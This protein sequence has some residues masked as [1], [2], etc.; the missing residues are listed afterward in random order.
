MSTTSKA[1][2]TSSNKKITIKVSAKDFLTSLMCFVFSRATL[3]SYMNPFGMAMYAANFTGTGWYWAL[4][5]AIT[6]IITTKGDMT[7]VRYI[8]A[9]GLATPVI[10]IFDKCGLVAK[11]L[12]MSLSYL[13]VSIFLMASDG[14]LMYDVICVA[15]ESFICFVSVLMLGNVTQTIMEYKNSRTISTQQVAS[16]V[17][18]IAVFILSC[19]QVPDIFGLNVCSLISIFLM[20]CI[21][22]G[23]GSVAA[24]AAGVIAGTV[25]SFA[26]LESVSVIGAFA[27]CSFAAGL[28]RRYSRLGVLLG[29]TLANG[30]ITAFLNDTVNVIIN[31][32]EVATA[33]IVF[34]TM[35]P[36]TLALFCTFPR[37]LAQKPKDKQIATQSDYIN[38]MSKSLGELS[39]IYRESCTP[40]KLGKKYT[41]NLFN[42][43]VERAC[44][45]CNLKY[46]C[47]QSATYRNYEYMSRMLQYANS[48]GCLDVA[49]L[50]EEF[51][52]QCVKCEEF[53]RVFNFMYDVYKTD[54]M[55]L[56]KMYRVRLVMAR[57]LECISK[58]MNRQTKAGEILYSVQSHSLQN[59]KKGEAVC[60]D[61]LCELQLPQGDY[62]VILSDGMGSGENA[63]I[64]SSD[65]VNMLKSM[66]LAGF[67]VADA[68][69]IINSSLIVRSDKESF[70]TIDL[71][72]VNCKS[73]KVT[74]VKVGG[75]PTYAVIDKNACKY[76]CNNLPVGILKDIQLQTY[77]FDV[78]ERGIVVM[79]SDGIS[80]TAL[81]NDDG[82]PVYDCVQGL[83]GD[84]PEVISDKIMKEAIALNGGKISDDMTVQTVIISAK[85]M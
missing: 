17:A 48:K 63:S 27:L 11:S 67:D 29:F 19:A 12:I 71:M 34:V 3:L 72:Y 69:E 53:V 80:N 22:L 47:W 28:F 32:I 43:C 85:T 8:L 1:T 61:S 21:A 6:G 5:A 2:H 25:V 24:A 84:S 50:P 51:A 44:T 7:S 23:S 77:S 52:K 73:G 76:E 13:A 49:G 59:A 14:F 83:E 58:A 35:P 55:W 65:T 70:S 78:K 40:R 45:S 62:A 60:G 18:A 30:V 16:I 66:M 82:D 4:V 79:V 57:Q 54:K 10:G 39:V 37:K 42:T 33:G 36:K 64:E 81:N 74:L 41:N 75:A 26:Y 15:F 46:N 38:Q 20:L 56:E 9:L 68:I 31:P